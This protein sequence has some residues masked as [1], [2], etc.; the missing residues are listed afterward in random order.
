M[1]KLVYIC[2][3]V[4]MGS[5]IYEYSSQLYND[6]YYHQVKIESVE[7]DASISVGPVEGVKVDFDS[8]TDWSTVAKLVTSVLATYLGY[9]LINK[10]VV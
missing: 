8:D 6:W 7:K 5:L 4:L 10:L 9:R 3:F 2:F 1:K